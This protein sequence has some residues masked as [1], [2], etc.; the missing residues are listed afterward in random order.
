MGSSARLHPITCTAPART[1]YRQSIPRYPPRTSAHQTIVEFRPL[2]SRRAFSTHAAVSERALLVSERPTAAQAAHLDPMP[3][4]PARRRR[5]RPA[6]RA[7]AGFEPDEHS[8]PR[9]RALS[10][11][12]P[13]KSHAVPG[14]RLP[15]RTAWEQ[16]TRPR[17]SPRA[18]LY[19]PPPFPPNFKPNAPPTRSSPS[20]SPSASSPPPRP[21]CCS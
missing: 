14:W 3:A 11:P 15:S 12:R 17:P 20:P 1:A 7:P 5:P 10:P 13:I 18:N 8:P 16:C 2:S 21:A 19:N 6:P 4:R 9:T